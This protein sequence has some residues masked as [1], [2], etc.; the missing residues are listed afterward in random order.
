MKWFKIFISFSPLLLFALYQYYL[1]VNPTQ[2]TSNP[3]ADNNLSLNQLELALNTAK[4]PYSIGCIDQ[5]NREVAI[6][7]S[8]TTAYLTLDSSPISQVDNLQMIL[9]TAN[10]R[11]KQIK[12]IDLSSSHPYATFKNH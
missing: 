10:I 3:N 8:D 2:I 6:N 4:I 7:L 5:Y 12:I 1:S 9:K 11:G